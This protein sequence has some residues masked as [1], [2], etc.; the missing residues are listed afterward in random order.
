MKNELLEEAMRLFPDGKIDGK[1]MHW[2]C[3]E[4]FRTHHPDDCEEY[5]VNRI[6]FW[7]KRRYAIK[8]V[9]ASVC[10]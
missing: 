1:I 7:I 5:R 2:M 3:D 10:H 4:C 9:R 6:Q 8:K